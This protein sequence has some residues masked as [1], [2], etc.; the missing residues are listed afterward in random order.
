MTGLSGS[1]VFLG[2]Q[3]ESQQATLGGSK[4]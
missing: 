4:K 2:T 3:T 1:E